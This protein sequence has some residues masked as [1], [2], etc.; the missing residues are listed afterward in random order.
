MK[1]LCMLSILFFISMLTVAHAQDGER[2]DK[3]GEYYND[4]MEELKDEGESFV[5]SFETVS[6]FIPDTFTSVF[7]AFD[8]GYCG[9]DWIITSPRTVIGTFL[10]PAIFVAMIIFF[11][12]AVLYMGAQL[13]QAPALIAIVKDE[14]YQSIMTVIRVVLIVGMVMA[15]NL[16]FAMATGSGSG[17]TDSVYVN[18]ND[19]MDAAMGFS[20]KMVVNM[21]DSYSLLVM[22]NMAIHTIYSSTM[23][24]GVSFRAMYNFNLG[25]VLKPIID[26][27]GTSLQY[28]SLAISEWMVHII[29]LCFIKR[30]TWGLFIPLGML[31]RAVPYTRNAGEALMMLI[32]AMATL[33]PLMFI[34]D[35]EA[36]KLLENNLVDGRSA[37]TSFIAKSGLF[38]IG[39]ALIAVA[40]LA[41]GV[42]FPFFLGSAVTIAFELIRTS[43]YYIVLMGM[44]LP[45]LNIFAT[46]T[47]AR[48][49]AKIFNVSV[50]FLSF[51]KII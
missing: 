10:A 12:L 7:S 6:E 48:E 24:V 21:I 2:E 8:P 15:S 22:Y 46:L 51:L 4:T 45:F 32:L 30:W 5:Q 29:V 27:V 50:N 37:L 3:F 38:S 11:S 1:K 40:L 47:L 34:V 42:I 16:W 41:G 26:I 36:H 44:V 9:D 39:G 35:Y 33:Y 31:L 25:P 23:W 43:V 18:S 13:L 49:L 28:L 19:V 20:R 14:F 17:V